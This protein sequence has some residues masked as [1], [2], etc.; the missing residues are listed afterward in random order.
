MK[1]TNWRML[2]WPLI[3]F[4]L[5]CEEPPEKQPNENEKLDLSLKTGAEVLIDQ[6][7][8]KLVDKKVAIIGNHTSLVNGVHLV[9][10]LLALGVEIMH[11]FAPEHGFRGSA[12][13]GQKIENGIDGETGLP[14][15][16]LYGKNRKPTAEQ[17]EGIDLVIFD[18]QDVGTRH[19]TYIGT[20]T[21]AMEACAEND[22]M[23]MVLDRPNPNGWLIDGPMMQK[24]HTSFIG[25]HE[26]PIAHGMTVAEYAKMVNGEGWLKDG[27]QVE[28]ETVLCKN[29]QHSMKWEETGLPWVPPSPNLASLQAANMYPAICWLEPTV[30]SLGRG[31]N[32]AF[33]IVGAPWFDPSGFSK[34]DNATSRLSESELAWVAYDFTPVS[35]PGKSTYP[36]YEDK[37]CQGIKFSGITD[38]KSLFIMGIGLMQELYKQH[39]SNGGSF[40]KK[41]LERWTGYKEFK[42]QIIEGMDPELM[43]ESWQEEV[44]EFKLIRSKYLLYAD[45]QS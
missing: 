39:S 5:A 42:E 29:Y 12:D 27:V 34:T 26:I 18:I 21:Y 41:G 45:H 35:L 1:N 10:T 17:L 33:T 44:E 24:S 22:K 3:F 40:F 11:V 9:D 13:A 30:V 14:I 31:T 7:M 38:S 25:M 16:S 8:E 43:W 15:Y 23:F 28:L 6:Y 32:E 19:Y 37:M 2:Y 4:M 36:K 20:M